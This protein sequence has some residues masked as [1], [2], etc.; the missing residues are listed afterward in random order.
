MPRSKTK[1]WR[2]GRIIAGT[3]AVMGVA[4]ALGTCTRFTSDNPYSLKAQAVDNRTVS[5]EFEPKS[6]ARIRPRMMAVLSFTG[7]DLRWEGRVSQVNSGEPFVTVLVTFSEDLPALTPDR[8][9]V[10][11]SFPP[12]VLK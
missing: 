8:V 4:A 12:E 6:A 2:S 10:D 3:I 7:S 1:K 5:A 11:T 9:S